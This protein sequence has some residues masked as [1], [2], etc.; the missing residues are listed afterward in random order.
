MARSRNIKP[1]LYKNEDLAE[2]SIWARY[3]FPGLWMLADREGRLED[4]PKRIKGELLPFDGQDVDPLLKELESHGFIQRYTVGDISVIQ[5]RSFLKHQAPHFTEKPSVL[6]AGPE[7][8]EEATRTGATVTSKPESWPPQTPRQAAMKM[9]FIRRS[10]TKPAIK[11]GVAGDVDARLRQIRSQRGNETA[12]L[13]CTV[14]QSESINE[15]TLHRRFKAD[16]LDGEWFALSH[17]LESY[18]CA[19]K[20]GAPPVE[21]P[22]SRG[23][24]N[25]LIPDSLIPDS[26]IPDSLNLIP[27]S[28]NPDSLAAAPRASTPTRAGA[29]ALLLRSEA[30]NRGKTLR[31][32]SID[33]TVTAWAEKGITD[34]QLLAALDL[35]VQDRDAKGDASAL[36]AG[37][38]DVM[39]AKLL[40]PPSATPTRVN[41]HGKPWFLTWSSIVAKGAEKGLKEGEFDTPPEFRNAVFRAYGVTVDQVRSAEAEWSQAA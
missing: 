26:L 31:L 35:A 9:Y 10:G 24:E 21:P 25:P 6:P 3:L 41:G 14:K 16:R 12:E 38:I 19:L 36:N 22:D 34:Q 5:I 37:F 8:P 28:P 40:N 2:C 39:L 7:L 17:T 1:G 4:R 27:D 11:I 15:R 32:A 30:T 13:I 29:I 20:E 33:R 23:V 18:I